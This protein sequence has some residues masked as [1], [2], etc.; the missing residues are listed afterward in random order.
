MVE[1]AYA[2]SRGV[3][4][5]AGSGQVDQLPD[6][7]LA[8]GKQLQQLVPNPFYG[9]ISTGTLSQP[10]VQRGQLLLPYPQYTSATITTPS[11]RD[12]IY[13]S[14]QMKMEKRFHQGGTLL[15]AYTWSKLI[16]NTDTVT[17]WLDATGTFQDY[18]NLR[19][20]RSLSGSDVPH[21]VVIS[22]VYDLPIGKGHRLLG[23]V[24][25]VADKL[26]S[27]WGINGVTTFQSGT[28]LG[29][30][31]N[32]NITG[33]YNGG[34][35]PNVTAG[36]DKSISGSA[37]S[38]LNGWFNTA[39]FT[40]APAFTLGSEGRFD[41]NLR[42][43]GIDNW[44]FAVFKKTQLTERINL[45]F[46]AEFFNLFNRVQFAAPNLSQGNP[47]FGIISSQANNPRLIQFALRTSF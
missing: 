2:G 15:V 31:S 38:R 10:T 41:P 29:L 7:D 35:R 19:L 43:Q 8:L 18:N 11:D 28:P 26:V 30:N 36:C 14:L 34:S 42:T 33:T 32:S 25:G 24:S 23:N 39:C 17:T 9:L 6:Q 5:I 1:A 13:H 45:Q 47:S 44:D 40:A 27:G 22:Y 3:H 21:H 4:L 37:T 46:R 16:S 12:S 20:E